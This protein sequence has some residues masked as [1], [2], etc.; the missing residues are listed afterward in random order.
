[1]TDQEILDQ[2]Q[3]EEALQ[4][5]AY[6]AGYRGLPVDT[7][8][9]SSETAKSYDKG[10]QQREEDFKNWCKNIDKYHTE[11]IIGVSLFLIAILLA[12]GVL[13]CRM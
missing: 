8:L 7:S 5:G 4:R 2:A 9:L 12:V 11:D 6:L 10:K 13:V 3:R 1:M